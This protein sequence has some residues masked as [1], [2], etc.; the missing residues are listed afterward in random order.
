MNKYPT[1]YLQDEP[2]KDNKLFV[3]MMV[4]VC[5]TRPQK[6]KK[7]KKKGKKNCPGQEQENTTQPERELPLQLSDPPTPHR[8]GTYR[9]KVRHTPTT[10]SSI[11][12]KIR[13]LKIEA[14]RAGKGKR[15]KRLACSTEQPNR[16]R[17]QEF[18]RGD[19]EF[20]KSEQHR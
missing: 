15:K 20:Y 1:L 6:T 4:R 14:K 16:S 12:R 5:E 10:T 2:C 17:M 9:K 8:K 13:H 19:F 18:K 11:S 7:E 3:Y